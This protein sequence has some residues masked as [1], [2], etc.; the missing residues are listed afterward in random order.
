LDGSSFEYSR[1]KAPFTATA[2]VLLN[3]TE[4]GRMNS[5]WLWRMNWMKK[6]K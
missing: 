1:A 5:Y 4:Y 3:I 6:I 2:L